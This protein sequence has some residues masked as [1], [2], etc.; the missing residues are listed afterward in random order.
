MD[1][2]NEIVNEEKKI[3]DSVSDDTVVIKKEKIIDK[4][5]HRTNMGTTKKG[6]G[7]ITTVVLVVSILLSFVC[8]MLG[9]YLICQTVSVEQVVK[10]I[11]TSELV[12]NSISSSVDKVYGS[13]VV[14]IA[15]SKGKQIS[16]G[17]G[18]IYKKNNGKAYI[19]TNNHVIDGADSVEVEFNDKSDRI[20]AEIVGGDTYADIAVLTIKDDDYTVVEMGEVDSLKLGDT[21]FTVGSPMGVNY[22]GTVTKGILSGKERM[23]EVNLSGT[24]SDY[25]MKVLQLDAAVNPGNSGGPLCDVSGKVI[26][27]ISL[28]IVQDEV[29]GMG[30]AIPIEDAVKYASLI[31][32]GG[33][34]SRPY[35]GISMLDLTEEYYLWQNRIN[36]PDGV[37][38]GIAIISVEDGTPASKAGLKKG[39]II[40]KINDDKTRTLAEFR[41][42]LYKHEVGEK[43]KLTFYRDGKEQSVEVTLGKN[44]GQ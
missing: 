39:D 42:E 12:E 24:S 16:T 30:F 21:I 8:G 33:E 43:I 18:F 27:I 32:E 23:V 41:Y 11:T 35:L 4:G 38:E 17:T 25:Y 13:T 2:E 6:N 5:S 34:I 28:K 9:A 22:K 3:M 26:G 31:E 10:N 20:D 14:V 19:M 29:E 44:P 37:D 36:I 15:S 7:N 1:N 40:V